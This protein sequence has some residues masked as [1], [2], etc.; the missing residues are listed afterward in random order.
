MILPMQ[1]RWEP[2]QQIEETQAG[3]EDTT[4]E[5]VRQGYPNNPSVGRSGAWGWTPGNDQHQ[6]E[7]EEQRKASGQMG[8]WWT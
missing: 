2:V 8:A 4:I 1:V 3:L 6:G 5:C 7:R